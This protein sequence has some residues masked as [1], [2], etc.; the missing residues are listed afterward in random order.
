MRVDV[1]AKLNFLH[2]VGVLVFLAFFFLLGL[3]VAELAEIDDSANGRLCVRGD[4]DEVNAA[5][6][7]KGHGL[8]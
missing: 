6:A 7:G 3:F 8:G 1:S 2:A 5:L 4:L